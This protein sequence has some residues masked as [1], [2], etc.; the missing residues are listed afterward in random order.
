LQRCRDCGGLFAAWSPFAQH[1]P[2]CPA[3][4]TGEAAVLRELRLERRAATEEAIRRR[5]E[6]R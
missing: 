2:G 3:G 4:S 1:G 5:Q 6:D